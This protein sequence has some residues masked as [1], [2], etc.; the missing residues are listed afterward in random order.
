[1]SIHDDPRHRAVIAAKNDCTI[2]M[3]LEHKE[4]R[5]YPESRIYR[6]EATL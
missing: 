4:L 5:K 1:V 6:R 2:N 3:N